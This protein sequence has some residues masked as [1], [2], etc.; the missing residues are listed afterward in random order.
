MSFTSAWRDVYLVVVARAISTCGDFLA[1]TA[2]VLAVQERGAGGG[3]VATVMIAAALPPVLLARVTGRLAD[4]VDSRPLLIG[5]GLAQ[6]AICCALAAVTDLAAM[7]LL[8]AALGCGLAVTN[9]VLSALIPAMVTRADLPRASA[10]AQT[11]TS[12]GLLLAPALGG[13]LMGQFGL[14]VPLLVDAVSYLAL[15]VA[16]L[17][18]RTRRGGAVRAGK[19]TGPALRLRSDPLLWPMFVLVGLV[20]AAVSAVNVGEVFLVRDVLGGSA[21]VYGLLGA[22]WTGAMLL[23]AWLLARGGHDDRGLAVLLLVML[24]VTGLVVFATGLVP[25]VAWIFP[26]FVIGGL[27]NGAE[28]VIAGLLIARRVPN[29]AHGL[30]YATYSAVNGAAV[31]TGYLAAG[32]LIGPL[33]VR[34]VIVGAGLLGLV[35]AAVLARPMLR[36]SRTGQDPLDRRATQAT[37]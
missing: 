23:G 4:R 32:L 31:V 7:V 14:R 1:A 26:L 29:T 5:A 20:V 16:G 18:I 37:A 6:A 25:A 8:I 21:T 30:A 33:P 9:P 13:V 11:A 34:W 12:V 28:N 35:A 15:A 2:L 3:A 17:L 10:L 27:S 36:G 22:T 24:V 19:A